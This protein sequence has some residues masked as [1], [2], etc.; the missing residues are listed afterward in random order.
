M[1][2]YEFDTIIIRYIDENKI[3]KYDDIENIIQSIRTNIFTFQLTTENNAEIEF[4]NVNGNNK[5]SLIND[6]KVFRQMSKPVR[7]YY[8]ILNQSNVFF[9]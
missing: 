3:M 8:Q 9:C 5:I 6:T 4:L 2:I 7:P 1:Q